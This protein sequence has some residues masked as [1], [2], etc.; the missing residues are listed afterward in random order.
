MGHDHADLTE[1]LRSMLRERGLRATHT[2]M[3]VLTRLHERR[4]P[5]THEEIMESIGGTT[6]LLLQVCAGTCACLGS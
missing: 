4:A 6:M 1:E 5:M 2:R 3:S